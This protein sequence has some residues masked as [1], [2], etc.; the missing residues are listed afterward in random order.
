MKNVWKLCLVAHTF[1]AAEDKQELNQK[2]A[3]DVEWWGT[4]LDLAN[5]SHLRVVR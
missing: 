4:Y 3:Y 2:N 1:A 5:M